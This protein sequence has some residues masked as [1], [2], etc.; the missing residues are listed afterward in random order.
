V[1]EESHQPGSRLI[2][3]R[4][5][6]RGQI[7]TPDQRP[8]AGAMDARPATGHSKVWKATLIVAIV[9]GVGRVVL[10]GVAVSASPSVST[11]ATIVTA[12]V[13]LVAA[14]VIPMQVMRARSAEQVATAIQLNPGALVVAAIRSPV[15]RTDF[16]WLDPGFHP[17]LFYS[18]V[19]TTSGLDIW[20]GG[21]NARRTLHIQRSEIAEIAT[22][23]LR[24][25]SGTYPAVSLVFNHK[26]DVPAAVAAKYP[27][28][29]TAEFFV[30]RPDR[31]QRPLGLDAVNAATNS[32]M[33]SLAR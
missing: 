28:T 12:A 1:L 10:L 20:E 26:L 9:I 5:K 27:T 7:V 25:G 3:G 15:G 21:R 29:F 6:L 30:R 31:P 22:T 11:F 17:K 2:E 32:M 33:E 24:L 19:V 23:N 18:I 14:I 8:I 13:V 4:T 16:E